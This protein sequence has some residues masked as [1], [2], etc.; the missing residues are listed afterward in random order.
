MQVVG[1]CILSRPCGKHHGML[2]TC[3]MY[4]GMY[5]VGCICIFVNV[6]YKIFVKGSVYST[7][8]SRMCRRVSYVLYL[9]YSSRYAATTATTRPTAT[10]TAATTAATATAAAHTISVADTHA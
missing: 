10:A 5:T 8:L 6:L 2:T 9:W 7:F 3:G 1:P 4:S